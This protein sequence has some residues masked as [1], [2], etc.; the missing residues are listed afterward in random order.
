MKHKTAIII[1]LSVMLLG[2]AVAGAYQT[3]PDVP[4]LLDAIKS[5]L[6]KP[7]ERHPMTGN[8][9]NPQAQAS[10]QV[11]LTPA[12]QAQADAAR[13][14]IEDQLPSNIQ[15]K[16][17]VDVLTVA[18]AYPDFAKDLKQS[19]KV[20]TH[21]S[22][23][24]TLEDLTICGHAYKTRQIVIDGVDVVQRVA[25]LLPKTDKVSTATPMTGYCSTFSQ[26]ASMNQDYDYRITELM[27]S[28][29]RPYT[30][31]GQARYRLTIGGMD[32]EIDTP[33]DDVYMVDYYSGGVMTPK[34]GNL[35]K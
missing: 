34:L 4:P 17:K 11:T 27:V 35:K 28:D 5:G 21:A 2:G 20:D 8:E 6:V 26:P 23:N 15:P 16:Q 18:M 7:Q 1:G 3:L 30:E 24:T 13:K 14:Q 33:S 9:T 19:G 25:A 10:A 29:V 32:F 12:Q 31:D 22:V